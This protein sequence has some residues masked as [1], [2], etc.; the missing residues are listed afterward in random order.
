MRRKIGI[1]V[2]FIFVISCLVVAITMLTKEDKQKGQ[3]DEVS[4]I[5]NNENETSP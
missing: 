4:S 5:E 1:L 2:I 3:T